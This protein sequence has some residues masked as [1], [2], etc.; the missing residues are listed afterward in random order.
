VTSEDLHVSTVDGGV[1]LQEVDGEAQQEACR[2][3]PERDA[4]TTVGT[5]IG[6]LLPGRAT[7]GVARYRM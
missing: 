3:E 4:M 7:S 1:V 5:I 2:P 6:H